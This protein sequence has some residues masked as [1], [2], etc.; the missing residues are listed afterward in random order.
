MQYEAPASLKEACSLLA[1]GKGKAFV[2]AGCTDLLV[3]SKGDLIEPELVI[4]IK[5][6]AGMRQIRKTATGFEIGAAVSCAELGENAALKKAWPG[7]VEAANL[8]GS[9]Q[10]QSRCT[11]VGNLCNAS[12]AAD[13]VPAMMAAGALAV[14]SGPKKKRTIPVEQIPVGPGRTSRA[15]GDVDEAIDLA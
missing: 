2:L 8:I 10:I 5:R 4:D 11:I 9:K 6:I 7:V 14:I 12:P 3:R 13:S 1:S 15:K